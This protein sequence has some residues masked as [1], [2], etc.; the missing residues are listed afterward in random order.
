VPEKK[1]IDPARSQYFATLGK[2]GAA[3]THSRYDAEDLTRAATD[4][5]DPRQEIASA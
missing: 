1:I 5:G 4:Q 3:V 2:I